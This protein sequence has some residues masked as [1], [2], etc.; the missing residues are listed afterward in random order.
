MEGLLPM[1]KEREGREGLLLPNNPQW[2]H[3]IQY[4]DACRRLYWF[5]APS[6]MTAHSICQQRQQIQTATRRVYV[7]HRRLLSSAI[8]IMLS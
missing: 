3:D 7:P 4:S 6:R 2:R 1:K 5:I 8:I